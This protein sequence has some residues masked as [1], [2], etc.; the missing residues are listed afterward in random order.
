MIGPDPEN[1]MFHKK[2]D[3]TASG[4]RSQSDIIFFATAVPEDE[5]D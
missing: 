3:Q 5:R 1:V 4:Y 2:G